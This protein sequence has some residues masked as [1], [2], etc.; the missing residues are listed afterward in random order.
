M[1]QV[2]PNVT[3]NDEY[4]ISVKVLMFFNLGLPSKN[5]THAGQPT[6]IKQKKRKIRTK[7][8]DQMQYSGN[9]H[10]VVARLSQQLVL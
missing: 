1:Q 2:K 8:E 10:R 7:H 5:S 6:A 9:F 4:W 3:C